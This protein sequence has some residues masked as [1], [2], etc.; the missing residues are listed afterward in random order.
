MKRRNGFLDIDDYFKHLPNLSKTDLVKPS[1]YSYHNFW[2]KI[3][4]IKYYF[5]PSFHRIDSYSEIIALH[6][7]K[8]LGIEAITY[9]LAAFNNKIGV[10]SKCYRKD[11]CEY[12][13]GVDILYD[14]SKN[15]SKE[16]CEL[17]LGNSLSFDIGLNSLEIIWQALENRYKDNPKAN[18]EELVYKIVLQYI[19]CILIAHS[20]KGP[21]NWEIEE[22]PE[23]I[24]IVP[25]FDNELSFENPDGYDY[26]SLLNPTIEENYIKIPE[27]LRK[28]LS[29]SSQE[30]ID[31]FL[32][33][34]N[35]LTNEKLVE[36]I[37]EV[38]EYIEAPIPR[39]EKNH[40][41]DNFKKHRNNI[42]EVLNDLGF[43]KGR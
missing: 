16:L 10:I 43:Y 33:K 6:I 4:G 31:L 8:H 36:I 38:E 42:E 7:A 20:D 3:D 28:F 35:I 41:M 19:F 32:E 29:I 39:S 37:N 5:K 9:D 24:D 30:Y 22:G 13:S 1:G 26:Y 12:V 23:K 18:I 15:N 34:F 17:G 25:L 2:I 40:F 21:Q 11:D 14:Y 27:S